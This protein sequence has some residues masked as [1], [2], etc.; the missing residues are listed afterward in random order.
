MVHRT[1]RAS[2]CFLRAQTSALG[3]F[4]EVKLIRESLSG[5][6]S[7]PVIQ[8]MLR[9]GNI[10]LG[11]GEEKKA[12]DSFNEVSRDDIHLRF[13]RSIINCLTARSYLH[14]N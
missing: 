11:K 2:R 5:M 14:L 12:L 4:E 13:A 10:Y 7:S 8:V 9:I 1:C 6:Q 3:I